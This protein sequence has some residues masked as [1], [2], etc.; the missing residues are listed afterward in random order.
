M[1][2]HGGM[3]GE[4]ITDQDFVFSTEDSHG[5]KGVKWL[6]SAEVEL[7]RN[8]SRVAVHSLFLTILLLEIAT[9][10]HFD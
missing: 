2:H 1:R 7:F 4:E 3:A 6:K 5:V 10:D 9:R 8:I